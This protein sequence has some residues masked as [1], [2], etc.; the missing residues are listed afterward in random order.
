MQTLHIK[1]LNFSEELFAVS[2]ETGS[3]ATHSP[4]PF[5]SPGLGCLVVSVSKKKPCKF[6]RSLKEV[7]V[8]KK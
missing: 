2:D 1:T 8:S 5:T 3:T 6:C 7:I 4:L